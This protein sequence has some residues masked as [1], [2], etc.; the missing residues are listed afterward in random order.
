MQEATEETMLADFDDVTFDYAG[1]TSTFFRRDGGFFARTDGRDGEL[2]EYRIAYT[3]GVEPLQQY[4]VSFPDGRYQAL[5]VVWDDRPAGDGG[6]R[7]V[8]LYP[9]EAIDHRDPLHWTGVYQNWNQM[10][11]ECHSTNLVKGYD[12]EADSYD[13]TWS[14]IDVSCEACHGPGSAHARWAAQIEAGE[15]AGDPADG[16]V[17]KLKDESGGVWEINA[18]TGI[19]ER[20]APLSS[21][22]QV[23]SCGRCHARR[24][25]ITSDYEYDRPLLDTHRLALLDQDLYHADGHLLEEVYVYGSF[26]QSKMHGAGVVCTDCHDPHG[27]DIPVADA[28]CARCHLGAKF[29]A[30]SHHFHPPESTGASCVECHMSSRTYMVVDG[31]RDHGFRVPRPDLSL[32]LGTPNACNDCHDDRDVEWAAGAFADWYG[33]VASRRPH[34]ATA[35]AAG[36]RGAPEARRLLADLAADPEMPGIARGTALSLARQFPQLAD[37]ET[38][39]YGLAD[40]DPIVRL[41]ALHGIEG[42]DPPRWARPQ[43]FELLA[44][45]LTDPVRAV[46]IAAGRLL[47]EVPRERVPSELLPALSLALAEYEDAQQANAD[48]PDG[49]LNLGLVYAGQGRLDDAERAYRRALAL[50]PWFSPAFVNLADL[51]RATGRDAEAEALLREAI[52]L[53]PEDS[54]VRHSLG[55]ALVRQGRHP[56]ALDELRRAAELAPDQTRYAYVYGVALHSLGETTR[57]LQVLEAA[58]LRNPQDPELLTGLA[59]ISRDAGRLE[60]ARD[61]ARKLLALRP[62][63]PG[64]AQLA[65]ELGPP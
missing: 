43:W 23:E 54:G 16:L 44:P 62:E 60:A 7:W 46:R 35:L 48:R 45:S 37:V 20:S 14:E 56:E 22:A 41:G 39:R 21:T 40:P 57:A 55:L 12:A 31:R 50:D 26:V 24:S 59:T 38:L 42:L 11:A 32:E 65:A 18:D 49:Q 2:H 17:V 51:F 33:D 10:C 61:F 13:T 1:T 47:A 19:A 29:A 58:H 27:L 6:Q 30:A 28:A 64:A 4:L 25:P 9:D 53:L 36:R 52:E 63:D 15:V 5:P 34:F 3:F 8:H